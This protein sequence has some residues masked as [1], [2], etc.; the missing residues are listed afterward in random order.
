MTSAG[1]TKNDT[2][3]YSYN[4]ATHNPLLQRKSSEE[5]H[6]R[7]HVFLKKVRHVS[8]DKKWES[9]SEQVCGHYG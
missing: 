6:R 7:R 1:E 4:R 9:R 8:D 2:S 3:N 5:Q